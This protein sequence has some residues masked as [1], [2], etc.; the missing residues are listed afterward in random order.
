MYYT[1]YFTFKCMAEV[2]HIL[3][4]L[5]DCFQT[6]MIKSNMKQYAAFLSSLGIGGYVV[7]NQEDLTSLMCVKRAGNISAG[8]MWHFSFDET[9]N[10][11]KDAVR[12]SSGKIQIEENNIVKLDAK[13]YMYRGIWEEDG[14]KTADLSKDQGIMEIGLIKSERLE[15]ELL[16]YAVLSRPSTPSLEIQMK[17]YRHDAPDGYLEISKIEFVHLIKCTSKYIG[18]LITPEANYLSKRLNAIF[19]NYDENREDI[20]VGEHVHLGVN[21]KIG[22]GTLIEDYS[23]IGDNCVVGDKCRIHRNVYIDDNVTIGSFVKIQNNNSIYEGVTLED[24]VFVGTNV[25]FTNDRYPRSINPDGTP[26]KRGDWKL[27]TTKVCR[28]AS[29]G[30]G[31]VIRCG[32]T[33]GEGAMVGCGAVVLNDVQAGDTVVGNP[34]RSINV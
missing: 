11:C 23:F 4:S 13:R 34:A 30:A 1:D 2:Y 25:S 5:K 14:I 8:E 6:S 28:G 33:I 24:G 12:D 7:I 29:I 18:R 17:D 19:N 26:V 31:A 15:I 22:K 21:L 16:G 27:E 9:S 32:I 10:V 3:R 20:K